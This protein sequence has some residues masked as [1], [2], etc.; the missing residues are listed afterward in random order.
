MKLLMSEWQ[1]E[2]L[3]RQ[4][5][6]NEE[7]WDRYAEENP[8][9]PANQVRGHKLELKFL[10]SSFVFEKKEVKSFT[11][12]FVKHVV[13]INFDGPNTYDKVG[14]ILNSVGDQPPKYDHKSFWLGIQIVIPNFLPNDEVLWLAEV[15]VGC[16]GVFELFSAI[17][18]NNRYSADL[19]GMKT[20][21]HAWK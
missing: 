21:I 10:E 2:E 1:A 12:L 9:L 17:A 16:N 11:K 15:D 14:K 20:M 19:G 3:A 7:S 8:D 5:K 6:M 4:K 13:G 18:R